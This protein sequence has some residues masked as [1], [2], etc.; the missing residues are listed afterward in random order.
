MLFPDRH[1]WALWAQDDNEVSNKPSSSQASNNNKKQRS[2]RRNNKSNRTT[3]TDDFVTTDDYS[4][5]MVRSIADDDDALLVDKILAPN[6][7]EDV[8]FL[9]PT[10]GFLSRAHL[11]CGVAPGVT[12]AQTGLDTVEMIQKE[13]DSIQRNLRLP[14]NSDERTVMKYFR[15]GNCIVY[16]KE[17]IPIE[18]IFSGFFV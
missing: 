14:E 1:T 7:S 2:N 9:H 4:T 3:T 6:E 18:T 11:T 16:L 13:S 15:N 8:S 5:S 12:A 10:F 17:P